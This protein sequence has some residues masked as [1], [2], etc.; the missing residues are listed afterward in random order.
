MKLWWLLVLAL[1]SVN[2]SAQQFDKIVLS[3][4]TGDDG[5]REG[6]DAWISFVK[7][8]GT[9][10]R[11]QN[12]A[13]TGRRRGGFNSN[14]HYAV[15]VYLG[16]TI[17]LADVASVVIRH[18]G[19]PRALNPLDTYDNW[20]I[21]EVSIQIKTATRGMDIYNSKRHGNFLVR[22]TGDT[23][24]LT[25]PRDRFLPAVLADRTRSKA[26]AAKA[27]PVGQKADPAGAIR[28]SGGVDIQPM[29]MQPEAPK[30][31]HT[32]DKIQ[33]MPMKPAAPK[34]LHTPDK[35]ESTPMKPEAPKVP[36]RP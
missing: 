29:P 2:V 14:K 20:D 15:P 6:N 23:R 32:P 34:A 3:V 4:K 11:E 27:M 22:F 26:D 31:A 33:P 1:L 18:D 36:Q 25:I 16:A 8:D 24:T 21:K 5:L 13:D 10:T 28:P 17:D 30:P 7:T 35:I 12:F 9:A 19:S